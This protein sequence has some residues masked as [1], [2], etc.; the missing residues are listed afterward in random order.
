MKLKAELAELSMRL[1]TIIKSRFD[2]LQLLQA[3]ATG[4]GCTQPCEDSWV[5]IWLKNS[6]SLKKLTLIYLAGDNVYSVLLASYS[7]LL[8]LED[9]CS[10]ANND[11]HLKT[12]TTFFIRYSW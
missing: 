9:R 3:I 8:S 11:L 7:Q 2:S 10:F 5:A 1:T 4:K 6:G 12:V